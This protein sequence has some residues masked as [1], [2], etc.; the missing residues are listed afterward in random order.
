[1][2]RGSSQ[3]TAA[4]FLAITI[5]IISLKESTTYC[6]KAIKVLHTFLRYDEAVFQIF[7]PNKPLL[8]KMN[9]QDHLM[10]TNPTEVE[11]TLELAQFLLRYHRGV[12]YGDFSDNPYVVQRIRRYH[13]YKIWFEIEEVSGSTQELN[14][15]YHDFKTVTQKALQ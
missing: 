5:S 9:L 12:D 4:N 6:I 8:R 15:T 10:S 3:Q 11:T 2:P 14:G 7:R 13:D 1:M